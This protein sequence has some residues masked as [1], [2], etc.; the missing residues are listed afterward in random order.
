MEASPNPF[1]PSTAI[2]FVLP[3]DAN[4]HLAV[5]D[6][7]GRL[8][9]RLIEGDQPAGQYDLVWDGKDRAGDQ[10]SSGV[11]FARLDTSLGTVIQK[12]ALIK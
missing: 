10:V 5:Y 7:K 9:N 12:L 11:Y 6:L 4:V 1:N 8:V 3:E 2:S